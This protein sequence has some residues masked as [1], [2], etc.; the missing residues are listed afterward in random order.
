MDLYWEKYEANYRPVFRENSVYKIDSSTASAPRKVVSSLV[1]ICINKI[2]ANSSLSLIAK[3][4]IPPTLLE[5]LLSVAVNKSRLKSIAVLIEKWTKPVLKLKLLSLS[6]YAGFE[7]Q[8]GKSDENLK[9]II[10]RDMSLVITVVN[11]ILD[12]KYQNK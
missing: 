3:D 12:L 2:T 10:S 1:E 9:S 8:E 5:E 11:R 7:A 6:Y 4:I